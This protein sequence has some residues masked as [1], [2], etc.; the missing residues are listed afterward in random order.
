VS[1]VF[2]FAVGAGSSVYA[3]VKTR[4]AVERFT[5]SGIGDQVAALGVGVRLFREEVLVG[6]GEHE[7]RLRERLA[8]PDAGHPRQ[9]SI[10]RGRERGSP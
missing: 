6:M 9:N 7:A 1:R 10:T 2:W 5:A 3:M 8:V 4:R